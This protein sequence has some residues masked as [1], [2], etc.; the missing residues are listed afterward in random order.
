M[1]NRLQ[2]FWN[3]IANQN[4]PLNELNEEELSSR[5]ELYK[6]FKGI[7]GAGKDLATAAHPLSSLESSTDPGSAEKYFINQG[8]ERLS[9]QPQSEGD[10]IQ[11]IVNELNKRQGE[12]Y[13][14]Q[15]RNQTVRPNFDE[16]S[17]PDNGLR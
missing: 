9:D 6:F 16:L 12:R 13:Q 7:R 14:T 3:A 8:V 2:Q 15:I 1:P 10:D 5:L 11:Q 4:R 17:N